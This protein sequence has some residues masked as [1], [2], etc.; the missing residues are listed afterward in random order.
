MPR[1]VLH[2]AEAM[3]KALKRGVKIRLIVEKPKDVNSFPEIIQDFKKNPCF[4]IRYILTPPFAVVTIYDKKKVRITTCI[5][6]AT[7]GS[8]GS[9]ALWSN[10]PCLLAIVQDY[11]EIMWLTAIE[12]KT[13]NTNGNESF[14]ARLL[15]R[16]P[17]V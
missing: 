7:A 12:D 6:T 10:D 15:N 5:T 9:P 4:K 1:W 13:R 3:K 16:N 8:E 14:S 11:F 17:I 2:L